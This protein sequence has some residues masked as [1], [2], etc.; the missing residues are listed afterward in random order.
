MRV[1]L[2]IFNDR[3][4]AGQ[5]RVRTVD[6]KKRSAASPRYADDDNGDAQKDEDDARKFRGIWGHRKSLVVGFYKTEMNI[7][8]K[9]T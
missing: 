2:P 1:E 9:Q 3:E 4:W 5:C 7:T 6:M 8:D